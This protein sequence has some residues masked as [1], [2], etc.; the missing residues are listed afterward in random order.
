MIE[1]EDLYLAAYVII[2]GGELRRV[3]V[4]ALNGRRLAVF[5]ISGDLLETAENDYWHQPTVDLHALKFQLRRLKDRAF[6]AVREEEKRIHGN[7]EARR[8]R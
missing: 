3:R 1:T 7:G 8:F 6:D 4:R 2:R 5:S